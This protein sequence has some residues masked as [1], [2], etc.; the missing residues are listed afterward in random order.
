MTEEFN[1]NLRKAAISQ[2]VK[3]YKNPI[4]RLAGFFRRSFLVLF[5]LA[6]GLF[7][8]FFISNRA[9]DAVQSLLLGLTPIFLSFSLIFLLIESFFQTKIKKPF[10]RY[11]CRLKEVLQFPERYNLADFV[12]FEL[13]ESILKAMVFMQ[14]RK[15][16]L[17][18]SDLLFYFLIDGNKDLNFIFFRALLD[19]KRIIKKLK[20]KIAEKSAEGEGF[21]RIIY[22]EDFRDSI[23]SALEIAAARNS[24]RAGRGDAIAGLAKHNQVFKSF[25]I[26][27]NLKAE[28][29]D[30]LNDWLSKL[31]KNNRE[32]R[33]FWSRKNLARKGSLGKEWAA[34][35]TP[36]LDKFSVDLSDKVRRGGFAELIGHQEEV[37]AIERVLSRKEK[38]NVLV[39]GESG[40]GRRSLFY[41]LARK[42]FFGES[43]PEINHKRIVQ[44]DLPRLLAQTFSNEEVE[45]T[46]DGIFK[47]ILSAGNVILVIDNFH[48]FAGRKAKPGTVDISSILVPYLSY[49]YFQIV[50]V[51]TFGG[52]H[53]YIEQNSSI[54]SL[55]EKVEA[56]EISEE[57]TL[58]LLEKIVPL[59][60]K[61][62]RKFISYL[63]LKN[64][65]SHC[66][67][68]LAALP[69]PEKAI[70]LLY[71]SMAYLSQTKDKV[72]L[73]KHISLII[74][75]KTQIPVGEMEEK[76][77]EILLN[78]EDL[79]HQRIVG[80]EEAVK[81]ISTSL[82]R[83]RAEVTIRKGPMG[84]FLFLGPTG[85]GKTETCKALA[86]IYFGS[87][88][89]MIRLDMSEFQSVDDIPRLIG[90]PG[91]EGLLVTEIRKRPFSLL[92]LDEIEKAHPNILNLFLQ[93]LDEGHLTDGLGRKVD[94]KNSIIIATSNAGYQVIL[95]ALR[96]N[97]EW[98]G[99]KQSL[100]DDL[101]EKGTFR[102]EFINR[103]DAMVV[104]KPLS[105]ENLLMIAGLMLKGLAKNL[106]KKEIELVI[107][108][109][110][111]EKIAELGYDPTF[112]ARRMRR[113]IQDK[114]ENT[115]AS[116][117]LSGQVKRGSRVEI[118]P[119][120]FQ[121]KS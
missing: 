70:D 118:D 106:Q 2:A 86:E 31:I 14:K 99:V 94:F 90:S 55:F 39:V 29:I 32:R 20:K 58:L 100:L 62:Y 113:V 34:G 105:R 72:L 24:F 57:E 38:N 35:Y 8:F 76:E 85:V 82:R 75:E 40:S 4:F 46:L 23:L 44:L 64:I 66:S 108:Q 109:A 15:I 68:Y 7:I 102:P 33:E 91:E 48:D 84:T 17:F 88:D 1:F 81:E 92:L 69:F 10:I 119:E 50:A 65:V 97:D 6:L 30:N 112:G 54:L 13:A 80:Q 120:T 18:D 87:E 114:I 111:K 77:K 3:H 67:R 36:T 49:P 21:N 12:N 25:L 41:E 27:N 107:S 63:A 101:F 61:K 19:R 115:L 56:A 51:S 121:I 28:D 26:E 83:A 117:I 42:S 89:K 9:S 110:I 78:L 74:T 5:S 11:D 45:F 47:E 79:I 116:A 43:S 52:F 95:E 60:E 37:K 59:L 98:S 93:V 103:F 22:S 73:P 16:S 104:F 96:S 71:E 53:R